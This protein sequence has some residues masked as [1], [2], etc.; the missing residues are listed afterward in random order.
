[1]KKD[2]FDFKEP[3]TKLVVKESVDKNG[4]KIEQLIVNGK[5][6]ITPTDNPKKPFNRKRIEND[7]N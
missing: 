2:Y 3:I 4:S 1:M 7:R 6:K 5:W